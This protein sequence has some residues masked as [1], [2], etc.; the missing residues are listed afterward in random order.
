MTGGRNPPVTA[1]RLSGATGLPVLLL[2]YRLAPDH[3]HPAALDDVP[4]T[5]QALVDQDIPA[6]RVLLAGHSGGKRPW[7]CRRCCPDRGLP[8]HAGGGRGV[9]ASLEV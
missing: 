9:R 8:A 3:P 5:Y 1:G 6:G 7:P 2:R 4:A